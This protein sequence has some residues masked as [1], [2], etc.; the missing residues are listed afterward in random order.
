MAMT[1]AQ[2][3]AMGTLIAKVPGFTSQAGQ[4][5]NA[6][7]RNLALSNDLD[8]TRGYYSFNFDPGLISTNANLIAGSGPYNLPG[9]YMRAEKG[10]ILWFN[11]GQ[12][13]PMVPVD[14]AEFDQQVQQA[15]IA[16]YP[17]WFVTDMS[18]TGVDATHTGATH[19]STLIDTL[20]ASVNL[21][22]AWVP[23]MGIAG[24]GIPAGAEILSISADGLSIVISQA[25]TASETV[26]LTVTGFPVAW[27]YPPPSGTFPVQVRYRRQMPDILTPETSSIIPWFPD[28]MYL[29]TRLAHEIM[30]ITDDDRLAAFNAENKDTLSKYLQLADDRSDRSQ[31]VQL[32]KRTFNRRWTSLRTTK[33]VGW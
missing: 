4:L 28:S 18:R 17:Q 6:L 19:T 5:L 26:A 32:D 9:D 16:N 11:L 15:G 24:A 21:Q 2:I 8:L 7:L 27:V 14:F 10:D 31:K 30:K 3:V 1:A 22:P 23:G 29:Y 12:P 20:S 25:A 13:Y 33:K